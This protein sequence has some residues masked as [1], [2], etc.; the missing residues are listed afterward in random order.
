MTLE[1]KYTQLPKHSEYWH[2]V[3]LQYQKV[4]D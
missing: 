2:K 3:D 4:Q 1:T